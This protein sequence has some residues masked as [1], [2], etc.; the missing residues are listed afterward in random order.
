[1]LSCV[2]VTKPALGGPGLFNFELHAVLRNI[3]TAAFLTIETKMVSPCFSLV[4]TPLS[5]WPCPQGLA[6]H[7]SPTWPTA[8]DNVALGNAQGQWPHPPKS[9]VF[10]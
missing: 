2:A 8:I 9:M 7:A 10:L 5:L 1:M 3:V 6:T 4:I